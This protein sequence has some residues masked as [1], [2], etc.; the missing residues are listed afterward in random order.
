MR[1]AMLNLL[2]GHH[3]KAHELGDAKGCRH[4]DVCCVA[5][6]SHH[7]AP[8][9]GM[10]VTRV[11]RVPTPIQKDV[12]PG[13]EI[14]W[15]DIDRNADVAQIAGA[16]RAGM[17]I[18]RQS[19]MARWAKSRQTPTPSCIRSLALRVERASG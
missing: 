8:D 10:V 2:L 17:F 16:I 11:H 15:I 18:Q 13:A 3:F 6:A 12:E 19:A 4:R 7:N 5:T 14:H 1:L 9:A